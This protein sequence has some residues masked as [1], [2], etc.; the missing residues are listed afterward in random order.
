M[1]RR[2]NFLVPIILALCATAVA[3]DEPRLTPAEVSQ[4]ADAAARRQGYDLSAYTRGEATYDS[5]SKTWGINYRLKSAKADPSGQGILS[6][7]INDTTGFASTRFWLATPT[8][9]SPAYTPSSWEVV[10]PVLY[11]AG[12]VLLAFAPFDSKHERSR[13]ARFTFAL[14]AVILVFV[15]T[16]ELLRH[17]RLWIF[18]AQIE[19]GF[20]DTLAVLRGVVLGFLVALILS[21]ELRG[22]KLA[23]NEG[24]NQ[25]LQPTAGRSD[26]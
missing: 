6:V 21:G 24:P 22:R 3:A 25:A 13:W 19:H 15:G 16:S 9:A 11:I 26:V 23:R 17:Y 20:S 1:K 8:P 18:S 7:D 12:G 2:A 10:F 4:A 14:T 5:V